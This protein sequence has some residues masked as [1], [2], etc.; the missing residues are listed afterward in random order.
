MFQV[1]KIGGTYALGPWAD[2]TV[3]ADYRVLDG[4][5]S[6]PA[7]PDN[8]GLGDG[9]VRLKLVPLKADDFWGGLVAGAKVP[10]SSETGINTAEIDVF[11]ELIGTFFWDPVRA[12]LNAGLSVEGDP[13][14]MGS[15]N[16]YITFSAAIEWPMI[17]ELTL[18]AEIAGSASSEKLSSVGFGTHGNNRLEAG[19]GFLGPIGGSRW[20][21]AL[22]GSAGLTPDSP[23]WGLTAGVSY[24]FGVD[25]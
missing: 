6:A 24:L 15:Q 14:N 4:R 19:L 22:A 2:L 17:E 8:D 9:V 16:D 12:H 13:S 10:L 21:W 3:W 23:D 20:N 25:R 11:F 5:P 7:F 18:M 1:P